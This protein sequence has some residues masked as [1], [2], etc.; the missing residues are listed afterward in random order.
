[1]AKHSLLRYH[2][3][4][5]QLPFG[6]TILRN[7]TFIDPENLDI[8]AK[9]AER[10]TAGLGA[11]AEA[12]KLLGDV[13]WFHSFVLS[14]GTCVRGGKTP[15]ILQAEFESVFGP[16]PIEGATVLDVGAWNGAFSFEAKRRGAKRVL[17][18]DLFTWTHPILRGLERF[19]FVRKD[20]GL[21]IDYEV[22]DVP[23]INTVNVGVFDVVLFLG[24]FY[25]LSDPLAA[26]ASLA[27]ISRSWLVLE[28][29]L[30][31]DEVPHPAMRYY[32]STELANDPTNWWGPNQQCVE[33][34]LK[35]AGFSYVG[36]VRN[37]MNSARGIFH[38][39]K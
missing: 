12:L 21:E 9:N 32:P 22:I 30:D 4:T 1:M 29:H 28:T 16:L 35:N 17:A 13:G 24:V 27:Q 3:R 6:R 33:G 7:Q 23:R 10:L 19:L 25:H 31:L 26:I 5:V 36:F 38:A 18:T 39:R 34:L 20:T 8:F 14:D 2:L 11:P 37:P 15:A